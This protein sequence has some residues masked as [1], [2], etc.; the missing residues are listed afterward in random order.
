MDDKSTHIC[1]VVKLNKRPHLNSD[2]LSIVD[3]E[4]TG[5]SVVINTK[6]W[7]GINWGIYIPP[8]SVVDT[9]RPEFAFL[10][11]GKSNTKRIKAIKLRGIISYGLLVP[12]P[13]IVI[14]QGWLKEG[15]N[16]ANSMGVTHYIPPFEDELTTRGDN[17][18][19]PPGIIFSKYDIDSIRGHRNTLIDGEPVVYSCKIHGSF[20]KYVFTDGIMYYGS[21]TQ[22]KSDN[23][24]SIW[25]RAFKNIP[26]IDKF[27]REN[28]QFS[29][30]G[31]VYGQVQTLKY[32]I[33]NDVR[34]VSFDIRKPDGSFMNYQEWFDTCSKYKIPTVPI[35]E[36]G[37]YSF[38]RTLFHSNGESVL[39]K[40]N[41]ETHCREG[42]VVKPLVER[43]DS[44]VG[45]VILKLVGD[46]YLLNKRG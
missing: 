24:N 28:P 27:C 31:E 42:V 4:D 18:K 45:R 44:K 6:E 2:N 39:A 17:V 26:N 16:F 40:S 36:V 22:W 14:E 3:I 25:V 29:L 32:G 1:P 35:L 46:D 34:F 37:P 12:I 7:E 5:Y 13:K 9:T 11:D 8:D 38:D 19:G 10:A 20:G 21:R 43:Y 33:K 23:E 30:Y 41:G 15:D